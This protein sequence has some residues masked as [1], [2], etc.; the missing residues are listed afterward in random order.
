MSLWGDEIDQFSLQRKPRK[1]AI[2]ET[3]V[4]SRVLCQY[5]GHSWEYFGLIGLKKCVVCGVNG[6]C[7]AC[8]P[9]APLQDAQPFYCTAHTQEG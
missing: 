1:T 2:V 4:H 8:T 3:T 9:V 7:P 6:Y 5:Q